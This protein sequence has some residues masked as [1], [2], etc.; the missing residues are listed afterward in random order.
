MTQIDEVKR[1]IRQRIKL[2]LGVELATDDQN[3]FLEAGI[4]SLAFLNVVQ[5]L[6]KKYAVKFKNDEL[7]DL[8][9]C[10]LLAA[11]IVQLLAKKAGG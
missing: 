11:A 8:A 6:E 4:D 9:N 10:S 1:E 7:P 5:A 3:F 2:A